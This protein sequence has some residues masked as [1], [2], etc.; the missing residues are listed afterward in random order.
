MANLRNLFTVDIPGIN[1]LLD[2][3]F[4]VYVSY[5]P[6]YSVW[7]RVTK[8]TTIRQMM[9]AFGMRNGID[10]NSFRFC[11]NGVPLDPASDASQLQHDDVLTA[12]EAP[13]YDRDYMAQPVLFYVT[14]PGMARPVSFSVPRSTTIYVIESE[15]ARRTDFTYSLFKLYKDGVPLD[16]NSNLAE[17]HDG[18]VL[19][20]SPLPD[21]TA[22]FF[23]VY[24]DHPRY[25]VWLRVKGEH[26]IALLATTFAERNGL[27]PDS[28]LFCKDGVPLNP[29]S[30]ASQLRDGDILTVC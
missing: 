12:R 25:G 20:I 13:G 28:I 30:F 29:A 21:P 19:T 11:K 22:G 1:Q 27:D 4:Q 14:G 26:S 23:T 24:V 7:L 9:N 5:G 8:S 6:R 10:P 15:V 2:N 17:F 16:Q 18:D 3:P